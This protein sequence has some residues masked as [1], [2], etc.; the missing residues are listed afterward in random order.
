[1]GRPTSK[2]AKMLQQVLKDMY[3]DPEILA[4]LDE[5]SKQILFCKMRE[6]QVR[7]WK[8]K[9]EKF[10][11]EESKKSQKSKNKKIGKKSV[12]FLKAADGN[13][14]VW[15]MGEH[16]SDLSVE[17]ILEKEAKDSAEQEAQ[18]EVEQL[19]RTEQVKLA[20]LLH[21]EQE[22]VEAQRRV[23]EEELR[24]QA[25]TAGNTSNKKILQQLE[26]NKKKEEEIAKKRMQ[27]VQKCCISNAM[28]GS[29]DDIIW[30][31]HTNNKV[32]TAGICEDNPEDSDDNYDLVYTNNEVPWTEQQYQDLFQPDDAD[33]RKIDR[34]KRASISSIFEEKERLSSAIFL[35][36]KERKNKLMKAAEQHESK[37]EEAW[38]EQEKK[39]KEVEAERRAVARKA[40]EEH[41]QSGIVKHED[42]LISSLM[43]LCDPKPEKQQK[44]AAKPRPAKPPNR[45]AVIRWFQEE[46]EPRGAG[47]DL[48]TNQVTSWFHGIISRQEAED[49]LEDKKP[50]T[51]LVR[52]SEKI[53]GYA[54]SLR[55]RCSSK[56][57]LIVV[58]SAGYKFI[59]KNQILHPSLASLIKFYQDKPIS[60]VGQ[61]KL[62]YPCGQCRDP[63]DT[64][65]LF[66][67]SAV[68]S[69]YL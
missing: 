38:R 4:E 69:S 6:E 22:K 21:D 58:S 65:E 59:G 25:K 60:A 48:K 42:N 8:E 35:S 61:E 23:K 37:L 67:K 20:R 43:T 32:T 2:G 15:V 34:I 31:E 47:L 50:G 12:N 14:W 53:Y 46:E 19:E 41:H 62:Q 27:D 17:Q 64:A 36:L 66:N 26:E 63:P 3:I 13:P 1:M 55:S 54:V 40:R 44:P 5:E 49:L 9:E 33:D 30:Q 28:G 16:E 57:F 39:A 24:K 52:V 45:L 10:E 56:H 68:E 18:K 51:F 11:K 29:K 7:R